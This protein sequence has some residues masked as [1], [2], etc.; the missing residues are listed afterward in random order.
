LLKK[1]NSFSIFIT[2][3]KF[4]IFIYLSKI[5]DHFFTLVNFSTNHFEPCSIPSPNKAF[6]GLN[7][8]FL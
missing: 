6:E 8:Q 4:I 1:I 3:I 2:F 7:F 5:L